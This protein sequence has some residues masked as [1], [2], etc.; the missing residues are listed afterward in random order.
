MGIDIQLDVASDKNESTIKATGTIIEPI[1]DNNI[2]AFGLKQA[3][4]RDAIM[5]YNGNTIFPMVLSYKDVNT[6]LEVTNAEILGV[7]SQPIIVKTQEFVNSSNVTGNFNVSISDTVSDTAT[8][9]WSTGGSLTFSQK[10]SYGMGFLGKGETTLSYT[11]SWG[12][13]GTQSKSYTVG[14]T[15][16]VS[17]E[18]KPNEAIIVE[19]S[20]SRGVLRARVEYNAFADGKIF[21]IYGL[22]ALPPL[23][24]NPE[25]PVKDLM[26]IA[27]LSNSIKSSEIIEVGYYSNA[28]I[29]IK[30]KQTGTLK[31]THF[32]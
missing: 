5:K 15:S 11:Q 3:V 13:G 26:S 24:L 19:L 31:T 2:E 22:P 32:I 4:M 21:A 1:N 29:E 8:N 25:I 6:T 20:A 9:T 16:G 30:D 23:V 7:T 27:G 18:L 12:I 14:S 10:I 17:V 28:R